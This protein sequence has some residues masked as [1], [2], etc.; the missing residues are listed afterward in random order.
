MNTGD[1]FCFV[2]QTN[3]TDTLGGGGSNCGFTST[4]YPGVGV[5]VRTYNNSQTIGAYATT[6][7][8]FPDLAFP[9]P[10]SVTTGQAFNMTVYYN[11]REGT[12]T[13]TLQA[14]NGS[15]HSMWFESVGTVTSIFGNYNPTVYA[16]ITAS[17]SAFWEGVYITNFQ[18]PPSASL[19]SMALV[20]DAVYWPIE[21]MIQLTS[22]STG[23]QD[24]A[25]WAPVPVPITTA[26]FTFLVAS[27]TSNTG[28]GFCF[29]YQ[30]N[31]T[32][33]LGGGGGNCGYTPNVSPSLALCLHTYSGTDNQT[34]GAYTNSNMPY[35]TLAHT[36]PY[37]VTDGYFYDV[38]LTYNAT[39]GTLT[40]TLE[41]Q[42]TGRFET[43][44]DTVGSLTSIFGNA[45][46]TVYTGIT[47]SDGLDYQA[48]YI[49]AFSAPA[50]DDSSEYR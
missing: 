38:T 23:G 26:A 37:S 40:Y 30:T 35:P 42:N 7:L 3:G 21:D 27:N 5:C 15:G 9:L 1:C 20:G 47:G 48:V 28:D 16:G 41:Q 13:Y 4:I 43:W 11:G 18:P 8:P 10:Y 49:S 46:P 22:A 33:T 31:G 6:S 36:I 24:G 50:E 45:N 19:A 12:V 14:A 39:E 44:T 34:I 17:D 25:A 2:V 32:D 29:V